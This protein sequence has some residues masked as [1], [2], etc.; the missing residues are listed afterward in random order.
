MEINITNDADFSLLGLKN[1]DDFYDLVDLLFLNIDNSVDSLLIES[2]VDKIPHVL[3]NNDYLKKLSLISIIKNGKYSSYDLYTS[4]SKI[5]NQLEVLCFKN[6]RMSD[7]K[8]QLLNF[9]NN[10]LRELDLSS[11]LLTDASLSYLVK[12]IEKKE[13]CYLTKLNLENNNI[14]SFEGL[15][16]YFCKF[17][18]LYLNNNN[19]T[20]RCS[21]KIKDYQFLKELTNLEITLLTSELS[22]FTSKILHL[23]PNLNNLNLEVPIDK[24]ILKMKNGINSVF[25]EYYIPFYDY[26]AMKTN[27][28]TRLSITLHSNNDLCRILQMKL[29]VSLEQSNVTSLNYEL[30]LVGCLPDNNVS[31]VSFIF[32]VLFGSKSKI[33]DFR[34]VSPIKDDYDKTIELILEHLEKNNLYRLRNLKICNYYFNNRKYNVLLKSQLETKSNL[35]SLFFENNNVVDDFNIYMKNEYWVRKSIYY[36][37][38]CRRFPLLNRNLSRIPEEIYRLLFKMFF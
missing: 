9:K 33:K 4:I 28:L 35:D 12:L 24:S 38:S 23:S 34:Y 5:L 14:E 19:H 36:L 30:K 31:I 32:K 15:I 10:N 3:S 27:K 1:E 11:N 20:H 26:I 25:T 21:Y 16:P 6:N 29:F 13:L 18:E 8:L 22:S 7:R 17:E 2:V 37:I